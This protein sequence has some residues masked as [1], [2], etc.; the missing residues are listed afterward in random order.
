MTN[1]TISPSALQR[2]V[3]RALAH[4]GQV[5]RKCREGSRYHHEHGDYY[6]VDLETAG[7]T[8]TH[9]DLIELARELQVLQ[10]SERLSEPEE[11]S[12]TATVNGPVT[13]KEFF[14]IARQMN[15]ELRVMEKRIKE[16]FKKE[17][18]GGLGAKERKELEQL[19]EES[20]RKGAENILTLWRIGGP[21]K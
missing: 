7:I 5:L 6:C 2:R 13:D 19:L 17:K 1:K 21:G 11:V 12:V 10:N 16:L 9:V 20:N 4:H 14:A 8:E 3:N 18:Y 15:K